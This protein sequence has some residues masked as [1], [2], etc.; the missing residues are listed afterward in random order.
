MTTAPVAARYAEGTLV[1]A[2]D[3]EWVVVDASDP[4]FLLVRPLAGA[5]EDTSALMP[6]LE[7]VTEATFPPPTVDDLGDGTAARL[8]RDGLRI[9]FRASGGPFRS[10]AGLAVTPRAYQYV[11]LMM[12]LRQGGEAVRLLIADGVGIGKTVE[13]GLIAAEL[14]AQGQAR[15]L[16]VLCSPALAPQWR[17]ELRVKF[18]I[19]A[20]LVLPSTVNRLNR[21]LRMGESLFDRH[22]YVVVS[23]DLIKQRNYRDDFARTCPDLVIV[24]EA[25]TSV[26]AGGANSRSG[27]TLRHALLNRLAADQQRHMLFLTATPHQGD[28]QGWKGL[29]ALLSPELEHLP[30]DLSGA[31]HDN[32]RR[33]LARYFVQRQRGDIA[34]FVEDTAFPNRD[35]TE[36]TYKLHPE[37]RALLDRV[38][39]YARETVTDDAI[40]GTVRQ[41]VRWW[42]MVALLR[43]LA[44]SPAAAATTLR[45]RAS[46][47]E[48]ATDDEA[49]A[50]G[51]N[52]IL[53]EDDDASTDADDIAP[54]AD[55][56]PAGTSTSTRRKLLE[57]ARQADALAGP[58]KDL[59]LARLTKMVKRL[60]ADGYQPIVFCRYIPTAEYVG[61]HL[62]KALGKNVRVE[63]VT[64]T[65]PPEAREAAVAD[66]GTH[67]GNR[68][69]VATD[70]LSE[71][72]NLQDYFTAVVHYD[73]AWNPTRHEQREGRIDRFGQ[74]AKT[75]RAIT[76]YGLDNPVDGVV[77]NVLLRK[78]E[79]IRKSTGVS[80]SLPA[81]SALIMQAVFEGLI[82]RRGEEAQDALFDLPGFQ[83]EDELF[84]TWQSTAEREKRSRSRFA[85]HALSPAA[86]EDELREV[87]ASLGGPADVEHFARNVL[88]RLGATL[89][90]TDEGFTA[91]L[92]T[93][94]RALRDMLPVKPADATITFVRDLPAPVG[95]HVLTRTNPAIEALASYSLDA[96]LDPLLAADFRPARRS[97]VM[98]TNAVTDRTTLLV[99][100]MRFHATL[101]GRDR[102]VPMVVEEAH[103]AAFTGTHD[104]PTWLSDDAINELLKATPAGN[105]P[106]SMGKA[107]L[108]PTLDALKQGHLLGHLS[109]AADTK[110]QNLD[111]SH[112]R[113]R[114]A[115]GTAVRGLRVTAQKPVDI[116][117]AYQFIPAGGNA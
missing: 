59:K 99:T 33:E 47:A 117:G 71:G 77:L 93:L 69:L 42:S 50:I 62:R 67:D 66:L 14:L 110:A 4:T 105:M 58:D 101:P 3:R 70:C 103:L 74:R 68:V 36:E 108:A 30:A 53:D 81:D 44:S 83:S 57:F 107:F 73:L 21:G 52:L 88:I 55:D 97:G 45:N 34:A 9:G 102:D 43:S 13:A 32:A 26:T 20:T 12:A 41:R 115:A 63:A 76:Y 79:A 46:T 98:R 39:D 27:A 86:V 92:A 22:P 2:R 8:L 100:R 10:L 65:M 5:D 35:T 75:V 111:E 48:A 89:L 80:V 106:E 18:N 15:G 24:D 28:E 54:G 116:L 25:H 95:A 31:Q 72:V 96:A 85:Q 82:L 94:P 11:P 84:N 61:E 19:D 6:A 49:D 7:S 37:Y 87:R 38:L 90:E 23:T 78:H 56:T 17:D 40:A 109:E 60:I 104:D 91:T 29:L 51:R 16:A 113:V 64:G 114:Q 112:R 1:R